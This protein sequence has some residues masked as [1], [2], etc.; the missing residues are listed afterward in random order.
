[1]KIV[2]NA[3]ERP[4]NSEFRRLTL[5][6]VAVLAD[7]HLTD[8]TDTIQAGVLEWAVEE[9]RLRKPDVIL[10][11]GD[12]TACGSPVA[13][14]H[15]LSAVS[16]VRACVVTTPGNAE[17]RHS[18][19]TAAM[20]LGTP[21]FAYT[22]T[23]AVIT[24][25]SSTGTI[26]QSERDSLTARLA[27]THGQPTLL[28]THAYPA[29]LQ[30]DSRDWLEHLL[31]AQDAPNLLLCAHG[32]RDEALQLP[33]ADIRMLRGLDPEK[34]IGG[35]PAILL[36]TASDGAW[37]LTEIPFT[38][39]TD[40]WTAAEASEFEGLLGLSLLE[41]DA[42]LDD[43][44][45]ATEQHIPALELRHCAADLDPVKLRARLDAWRAGGGRY[46]SWHL[47]NLRLAADGS[48]DDHAH[49]QSNLQVLATL[50]VQAV[51]LHPPSVSCQ[52]MTLGTPE[53]QRITRL[54]ADLIDAL[55][56]GTCVALEN[57][58][59]A[60]GEQTDESRGFGYLPAEL[61]AWLAE[62]RP[63]MPQ[64]ESGILLDIGHARNNG[65]FSSIWTLGDW[66]REIGDQTVGY[67]LHQVVMQNGR[68][69]N[70]HPITGL[71]GPLI[72]HAAFLQ[73]WQCGQLRHRP[74]FIEVRGRLNAQASY[75]WL[76]DC[77]KKATGSLSK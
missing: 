30:S 52:M 43:I 5:F 10:L 46:L 24:L 14:T 20:L 47:P 38:G 13:A 21:A 66:F 25:D 32:H 68:K 8:F 65:P 16:R 41:R 50:N 51:T 37:Q 2:F 67:H 45:Y 22:E 40:H 48:L 12:M 1:M 53:R 35:P 26:P 6:T 36:A 44:D 76:R 77:V 18:S 64:R 7:L 57:L 27:A 31:A 71:Y 9:L 15:V 3:M 17:H 23:G 28:A 63:L 70:H 4:G 11:L 49:W 42:M 56:A 54:V 19:Q 33:R 39:A 60:A 58:H 55:P 69:T 73:A 74:A 72:A 34:A 61:T 29:S 59:M 62:L 75:T